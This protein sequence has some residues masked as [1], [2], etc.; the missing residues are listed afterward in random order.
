MRQCITKNRRIIKNGWAHYEK[1]MHNKKR[2][3]TTSKVPRPK[4]EP[5]L[6]TVM[7]GKGGKS[8]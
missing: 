7:G 4:Q 1:R 6:K 3:P 8:M 5:L 2:V